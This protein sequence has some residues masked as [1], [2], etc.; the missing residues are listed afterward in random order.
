[1][2][3][4]QPAE[5]EEPSTKATAGIRVLDILNDDF[6]DS[7]RLT[8]EELAVMIEEEDSQ[9]DGFIVDLNALLCRGCGCRGRSDPIKDKESL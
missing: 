3:R 4:I 5:P 1:M 7:G 9:G 2:G 8:Y 6:E